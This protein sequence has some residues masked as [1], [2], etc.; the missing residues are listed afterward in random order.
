MVKMV[1]GCSGGVDGGGDDDDDDDD[2][3]ARACERVYK[4]CV[5]YR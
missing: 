3:C 5:I 1:A 4:I 2:V